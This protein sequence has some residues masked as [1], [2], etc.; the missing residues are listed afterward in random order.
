MI[1]KLDKQKQGKIGVIVPVIT[2]LDKNGCIAESAFRMIIQRCMNAGVHGIFIGGTAGIGPLLTESQ[3]RRMIEIG[4]EVVDSKYILMGGVIATSTAIA[5]E[6][7]RFLEQV[8]YDTM[9][10][11]PTYYIRLCHE[12]QMLKHYGTCREATNMK[13]VVYNIPVCTGVSI[14]LE[15]IQK[16]ISDG[17]T[18]LIKESSGDI[19]YFRKLQE[20]CSSQSIHLLQG[21]EAHIEWSL[22]NGASGIVPVCANY[23][24]KTFVAAFRAA[25]EGDLE[26]LAKAQQRILYLQKYLINENSNWISNLNYAMERLGIKPCNPPLPLELLSLQERKVVR[27]LKVVDITKERGDGVH[28]NLSRTP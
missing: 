6:K 4:R 14:S 27:K 22:K 25:C 17:W 7:I 28:Y 5:L 16:M 13:M 11:T 1:N 19:N 3:W 8:G 21:S 24:P 2:P 26:L 23:E 9:V 20:I 18:K 10:V 12:G 15:T